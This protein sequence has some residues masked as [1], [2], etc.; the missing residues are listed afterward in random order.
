MDVYVY[1]NNCD[2][3]VIVEL[4][5]IDDDN[6]DVSVFNFYYFNFGFFSIIDVMCQQV[7]VYFNL[8]I[9]LFLVKVGKQL[10]MVQVFSL[11]GQQVK[12]FIYNDGQWYDIID[13]LKGIY[14]VCLIDCDVQQF[15][16][17]L[18]YKF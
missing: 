6:V 17:K 10:V 8:F 9:G 2:G 11:I 3:F 13:L 12:F 16:I 7:K 14:F 1:F 18:M 15:V 4:V 5:V